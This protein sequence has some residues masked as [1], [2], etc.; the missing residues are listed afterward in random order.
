MLHTYLA[1]KNI[2]G[3][4]QYSA[5]TLTLT[6]LDNTNAIDKDKNAAE[7]SLVLMLKFPM[8]RRISVFHF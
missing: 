2:S 4:I 1:F 3:S 7:N 5:K 8:I 6:V